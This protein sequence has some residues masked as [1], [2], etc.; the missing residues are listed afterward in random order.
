M[1]LRHDV[2]LFVQACQ[3]AS[4]GAVTLEVGDLGADYVRFPPA[5]TAGSADYVAGDDPPGSAGLAETALWF[6]RTRR[7]QDQTGD[8]ALLQPGRKDETE[9]KKLTAQTSMDAMVSARAM[10]VSMPQYRQ[11]LR[12]LC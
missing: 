12:R 3:V 2:S 6:Q 4:L 5:T 8:C 11:L 1:S 7:S 10:S 9:L